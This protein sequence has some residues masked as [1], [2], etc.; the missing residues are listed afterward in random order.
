MI[1]AGGAGDVVG[2][3]AKSLDVF[4]LAGEGLASFARDVQSRLSDEDGSVRLVRGWR[5]SRLLCLLFYFA[6]AACKTGLHRQ[7]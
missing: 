6:G 2:G 5:V 4:D 7:S 1:Y 3:G